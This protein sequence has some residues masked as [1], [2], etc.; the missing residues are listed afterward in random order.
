MTPLQLVGNTKD[1]LEMIEK[2][3]EEKMVKWNGK[4]LHGRLYAELRN[5]HVIKE[6]SNEWLKIGKGLVVAIQDQVI[7]T[8][9]YWRVIMKELNI[10]NK[11]RKCRKPGETI[12][13]I[14]NG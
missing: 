12:A 3:R 4:A 5:P 1:G 11:C 7:A 8:N 2:Y 9:N 13:H 10:E 6:A 14:I